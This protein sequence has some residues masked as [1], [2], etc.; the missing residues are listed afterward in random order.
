[1]GSTHICNCCWINYISISVNKPKGLCCCI[2]ASNKPELWSCGIWENNFWCFNFYHKNWLLDLLRVVWYTFCPWNLIS[3]KSPTFS[4]A[5]VY[6]ITWFSRKNLWNT[7]GTFLIVLFCI[8]VSVL[9]KQSNIVGLVKCTC[10]F[11][12]KWI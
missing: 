3:A 9:L 12:K 2:H 8:D 11:F 4:C 10:V 5:S 7:Y 6:F 1:M